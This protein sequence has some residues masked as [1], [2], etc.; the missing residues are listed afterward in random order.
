M[1]L[2]AVMMAHGPVVLT[3]VPIIVV[4]IEQP[5]HLAAHAQLF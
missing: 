3:M 1:V 4:A 5:D 2:N